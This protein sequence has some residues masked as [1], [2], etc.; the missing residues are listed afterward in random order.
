MRVAFDAVVLGAYLQPEAQ[1]PKRVSRIPDRIEYLVKTLEDANATIIIPSPALSEFL[2]LAAGDGPSYLSELTSN[3]VFS[4]E[5]FDLKS[6]IEAATSEVKATRDGDK[7]AGATGSWQKVKVDRQ[8]VAIAKVH[9]VDALY[10][11]D[12]DLKKLAAAS[13]VCVKGAADLALPSKAPQQDS[14]FAAED[15]GQP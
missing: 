2:V 7:R 9:G 5:P 8:I 10:S 1:Y 3:R 11:D 4:I 12:E 15:Q 6:A 13:G 14:L